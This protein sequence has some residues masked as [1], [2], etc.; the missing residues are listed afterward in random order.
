MSELV[1]PKPYPSQFAL[2]GESYTCYGSD[3]RQ[4]VEYRFNNQGYRSEFDYDLHDKDPLLICLGSSIATGHGLDAD[5]NFGYLVAKHY[6]KKFWNLGQGCFRS[7]NATIL[8]QLDFLTRTE[9][10]IEFIVIQ[11]T[12]INR[13]GT[14]FDSYLEL[15]QQ[16]ALENFCS[17]LR[18]VSDLLGN[19]RWCWILTDYSNAV[20]PVW[21]LNHPNKVIIDPLTVDHVDV[22]GYQHLAPTQQALRMLSLH[23][24]PGWHRH[25][26][27]QIISYFNGTVPILEK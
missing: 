2:A 17:I 23:P 25:I 13:Q 14:R 5:Q 24:G 21:V 12:H 15:D 3:F 20:M 19:R 10:S 1:F 18:S 6:D 22:T 8:D 27:D 16:K 11:F 9:L 26:A 4:C 7:S